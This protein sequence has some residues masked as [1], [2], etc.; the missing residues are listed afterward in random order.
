MTVGAGGCAVLCW[1]D[2]ETSAYAPPPAASITST[3]T[4]MKAALRPPEDGWPPGGPRLLRAVGGRR[5]RR[6]D[7]GARWPGA[8]YT[9]SAACHGPPAAAAT[10]RADRCAVPPCPR[11]DPPRTRTR[12]GQAPPSPRRGRGR[13]C[14][15]RRTL[16]VDPG[17]VRLP[18]YPGGLRRVPVGSA[19]P[20]CGWPR[21]AGPTG[22]ALPAARGRARSAAPRIL[23]GSPSSG[24]TSAAGSAAS[25]VPVAVVSAAG[26]SV[27]QP[28]QKRASPVR[29]RPHVAQKFMVTFYLM[30]RRSGPSS[31]RSRNPWR[32]RVIAPETPW[33]SNGR[34]CLR[35]SGGD[36]GWQSGDGD[37][38]R[39][40]EPRDG[41]E[42]EG[43]HRVPGGGGEHDD[44]RQQDE[45]AEDPARRRRA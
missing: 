8:A 15:R 45:R 10:P 7:A 44:D 21:P 27:P 13:E 9:V 31:S 2:R 40:R 11:P 17:D 36:G 32:Y 14:S 22:A 37:D 29:W 20:A 30:D 18:L 4:M 24:G 34:S 28:P 42:G 41:E 33:I 25:G 16:R 26:N 12:T 1:F 38:D 35:V 23:L 39:D 19:F 3:T 43:V 6:G 5:L